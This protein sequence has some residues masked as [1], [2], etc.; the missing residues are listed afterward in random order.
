[1]E[2]IAMANPSPVRIGT[3]SQQIAIAAFRGAT[4]MSRIYPCIS[5]A[6][7]W[8]SDSR[9]LEKAYVLACFSELSY[10]HLAKHEVPGRDRYKIFPSLLLRELVQDPPSLDLDAVTRSVGDFGASTF[11]SSNFVYVIFTTNQFVVVAV[12]GTVSLRD[13]GINLTALRSHGKKRGYHLGFLREAESAVVPLTDRIKPGTPVYFT[14][15]S[16][17]GAVASILPSVF[18]NN[19]T[20]MTAYVFASPRFANT[21]LAVRDAPYAYVRAEDIVPHL[22][23]KLFGFGNTGF[24]PK[25]IPPNDHW[26]SGLQALMGCLSNG[27]S[28]TSVH[29]ME[30]YRHLLGKQVGENFSATVYLDALKKQ[31]GL[32]NYSA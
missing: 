14:G 26:R 1:M 18:P 21:A 29:S 9:S 17:G 23:P 7:D 4:P 20:R 27:N 16:L 30:N 25:L 11:E 32:E 12:R 15:H 3:V 8:A 5:R 6:R 19:Y 10:L 13:W 24:P 22:P 2:D 31:L 28:I